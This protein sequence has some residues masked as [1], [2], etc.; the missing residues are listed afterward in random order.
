MK[1]LY[2]VRH[3]IADSFSP[4][5]QDSGRLL[6][7]AGMQRARRMAAHLRSFQASP[8]ALVVSP[9]DR[10]Q[11]TASILAEGLN[12]REPIETDNRLVPMGNVRDV[13]TL[14]QEFRE[15]D[16]LMLV[17]HEPWM[18]CAAA[19]LLT[20]GRLDI[21]FSPGSVCCI[22]IERLYPAGGVMLWFLSGELAD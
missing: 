9:F 21:H 15:V 7:P 18:S 2:L 1:K 8:S 13:A 3:S 22:G 6:T 19:L 10:A 12:F 20:N 16:E 11:Q 5:G 17:G 4:T 14:L